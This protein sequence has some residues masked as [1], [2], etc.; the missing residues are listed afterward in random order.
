MF[1][2]RLEK[3]SKKTRISSIKKKYNSEPNWNVKRVTTCEYRITEYYYSLK[4]TYFEDCEKL[5]T[6]ENNF[7][8]LD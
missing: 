6:G 2:S 1:F 4:I 7:D 3:H 8:N 5:Y